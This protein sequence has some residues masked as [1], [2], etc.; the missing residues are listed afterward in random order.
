MTDNNQIDIQEIK[1]WMSSINASSGYV[2]DM[3]KK[4]VLMDDLKNNPV[5]VTTPDPIEHPVTV[6]ISWFTDLV[7][8]A[9]SSIF[10]ITVK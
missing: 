6:A 10:P 8:H 4:K 7:L 2:S 1:A 5:T 9:V 3:L